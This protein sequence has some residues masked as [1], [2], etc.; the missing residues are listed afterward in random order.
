MS[1]RTW[2]TPHCRRRQGRVRAADP[3]RR[4]AEHLGRRTSG[5]RESG[6]SVRSPARAL[7]PGRASGTSFPCRVRSSAP[8][9]PCGARRRTGA[10]ATPAPGGS[11]SERSL[12]IERV[13]ERRAG[14]MPIALIHACTACPGSGDVRQV[15]VRDRP[16]RVGLRSPPS[17]DVLRQSISSMV[18]V[19]LHGRRRRPSARAR[20]RP[21][22]WRRTAGLSGPFR[23]PT[24]R[25]R[26]RPE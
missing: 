16:V 2:S 3:D 25:R 4:V 24:R 6:R 5:E 12:R 15:V 18:P 20:G 13:L 1:R 22:P 23:L 17:F 7:S 19:S 26:P 14:E 11:T 10:S 8:R 9:A 21:R